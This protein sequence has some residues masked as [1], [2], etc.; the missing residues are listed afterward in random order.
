MIKTEANRIGIKKLL[1]FIGI[2]LLFQCSQF[3]TKN[4]VL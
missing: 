2:L 3:G 4:G 1:A